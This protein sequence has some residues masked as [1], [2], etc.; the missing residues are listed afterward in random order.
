MRAG[1]R[2]V[3]V[4]R[5]GF[6]ALSPEDRASLVMDDVTPHAAGAGGPSAGSKAAAAMGKFGGA[7]KKMGEQASLFAKRRAKP[8]PT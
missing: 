5:G 4:V 6:A 2:R 7:M 1:F 8:T 3:G